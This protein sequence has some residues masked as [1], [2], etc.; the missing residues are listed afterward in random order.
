M[1]DILTT[2]ITTLTAVY[3]CFRAIKLS[4]T[5]P[6]FET[7]RMYEDAHPEAPKA[8]SRGPGRPQANPPRPQPRTSR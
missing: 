6:W 2:L 1:I 7:R 8:G 5:Q 4:K 3:A